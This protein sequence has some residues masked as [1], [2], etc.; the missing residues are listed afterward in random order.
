MVT[1]AAGFVV[2]LGHRKLKLRSDNEPA[3]VAVCTSLQKALRGLGL[4]VIK[5]TTPVESHQSNGPVEQ[6]VE[7][8][9]QHAAVLMSDLEQACGAADGQIR[10]A[11]CR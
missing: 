7:I 3:V 1:E 10:A 6:T 5:D 2:W 4:D 8:V 11:V 9:R